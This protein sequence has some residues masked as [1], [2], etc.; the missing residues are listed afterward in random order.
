M[1]METEHRS[2]ILDNHLL[3]ILIKQQKST[4]IRNSCTLNRK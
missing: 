3:I 4:L 2:S 1:G